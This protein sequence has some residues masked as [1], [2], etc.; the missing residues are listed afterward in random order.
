MEKPERVIINDLPASGLE[1]L[2]Y[3]ANTPL[4]LI[5][6]EEHNSGSAILNVINYTLN[7]DL[8]VYHNETQIAIKDVP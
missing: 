5:F 2:E 4:Y 6:I 1:L 8:Q 7:G 3:R